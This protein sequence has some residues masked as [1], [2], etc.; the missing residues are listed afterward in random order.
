MLETPLLLPK[1]LH[2]IDH[3][4]AGD[5]ADFIGAVY[6]KLVELDKLGKA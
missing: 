3:H 1:H 4:F 5:V 2:R 6:S